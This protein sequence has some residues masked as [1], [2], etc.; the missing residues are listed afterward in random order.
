MLNK[1]FE[2]VVGTQI[3]ISGVTYFSLQKLLFLESLEKKNI[4][5]CY[6]NVDAKYNYQACFSS[7]DK[8]TI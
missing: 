3:Q 1:L 2:K 7:F 4:Q 5:S 8:L 6:V